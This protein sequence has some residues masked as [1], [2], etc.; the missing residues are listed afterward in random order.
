MPVPVHEVG[1]ALFHGGG[2]L[3]VHIIDQVIY[4]GVGRRHVTG[5][6]GQQVFLG[7]LAHPLFDDLDKPGQLHRVIAADVVDS[8]RRLAGA[9]VR[10]GTAPVFVGLGDVIQRTDDTLYNIVDVG[11]V[12]LMVAVVEH[13]NRLAR[14]NLLGENIHSYI[15]PDHVAMFG[16]KPQAG[17]RQVV[18]VAVGVG[19]QLVGLLGGRVQA[20]GVVYVVMHGERHGFVSAVYRAAGCVHQVLHTV[21]T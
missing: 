15:R 13:I 18:Q 16:E 12:T 3:V 17:G 5:L 2:R 9:W 4:I 6:Q 8:I 19:H 10:L 1:Y 11:E 14:Q 20:Q 7:L 21:M